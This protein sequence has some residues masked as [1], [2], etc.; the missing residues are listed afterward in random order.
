MHESGPR[1]LSIITTVG[2]CKVGFDCATCITL[3]CVRTLTSD[4]PMLQSLSKTQMI[5][6]KIFMIFF[7]RL[8]KTVHN[9][10]QNSKGTCNAGFHCHT[11]KK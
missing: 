6:W 5:S 3:S 4:Q 8:T 1:K 9:Y 2:V 10:S 7:F 11:I